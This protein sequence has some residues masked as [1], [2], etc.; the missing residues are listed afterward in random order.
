MDHQMTVKKHGLAHKRKIRA[1]GAYA[2]QVGQTRDHNHYG[3]F[4]PNLRQ[5]WFE[6]YDEAKA[7]AEQK[8]ER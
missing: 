8:V 5:L 1:E 4:Q 7:A 3:S 6:G 2:F